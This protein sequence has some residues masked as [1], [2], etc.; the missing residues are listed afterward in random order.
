M[1]LTDYLKPDCIKTGF[2]A[3]DKRT[4]LELLCRFIEEKHNLDF[5]EVLRVVREREALGSTG[6]GGGVALPHGKSAQ[7]KKTALI[8]AISPAGVDFDSL[9]G[10]PT[11]VFVLMV[12]PKNGEGSEHL[13]ILAR[14]GAMFKAAGTVENL[15]K[16]SSS[17]EVFAYLSAR[18]Q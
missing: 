16:A 15:S 14:L 10:R 8:M 18:G 4:A 6:V 12:T 5:S 17:E 3:A 2:A 13:S 7:A 1:L 11:H 9:D